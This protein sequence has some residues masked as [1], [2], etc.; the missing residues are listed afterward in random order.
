MLG[1]TRYD[2]IGSNRVKCSS[3]KSRSCWLS[4]IAVCAGLPNITASIHISESLFMSARQ[5]SRHHPFI[6]PSIMASTKTSDHHISRFV[7]YAGRAGGLHVRDAS[8]IWWTPRPKNRHSPCWQYVDGTLPSGQ[9]V[10][11]AHVGY[12]SV[13]LKAADIT[14]R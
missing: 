13:Q 11:A 4:R 12:V 2:G 14:L 7:M 3:S 8:K 1:L 5:K 6:S 10:K 9:Y